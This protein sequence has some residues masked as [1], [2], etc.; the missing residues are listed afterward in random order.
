MI[1]QIF[2]TTK[3]PFSGGLADACQASVSTY[4]S[5]RAYSGFH[6]PIP[7]RWALLGGKHGVLCQECGPRRDLN[8]PRWDRLYPSEIS[9]ASILIN[10]QATREY[11]R[12]SRPLSA[13]ALARPRARRGLG[14]QASR[15]RGLRDGQERE[16]IAVGLAVVRKLHPIVPADT[17]EGQPAGNG[18]SQTPAGPRYRTVQPPLR[19]VAGAHG[20]INWPRPRLLRRN[21]RGFLGLTMRAFARRRQFGLEGPHPQSH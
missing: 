3:P 2:G 17:G 13:G 5:T 8:G 7:G 12:D 4:Q 1:A 21:R 9:C 19:N 16:G 18:V 15:Q 14:F 11:A 10:C 6:G 20:Y